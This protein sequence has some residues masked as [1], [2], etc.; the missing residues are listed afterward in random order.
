LILHGE[1]DAALRI[2]SHSQV[3]YLNWWSQRVCYDAPANLG[4]D[5]ICKKALGP[6][7][8]LN[9][10]DCFPELWDPDSGRTEENDY[11]RSKSYQMML[12]THTAGST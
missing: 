2:C 12:R 5:Q 10:M 4:W 7:I 3:D 9:M 6:Y 1:I 11:R 8:S